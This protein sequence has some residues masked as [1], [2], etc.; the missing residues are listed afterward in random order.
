MFGEATNSDYE[1]LI[2]IVRQVR[3]RWRVR[4]ALGNDGFSNAMWEES[5]VYSLKAIYSYKQKKS[6]KYGRD[7][8]QGKIESNWLTIKVY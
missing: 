5:G 6:W 7:L 4:V 2:R 1:E 3:N 8:W